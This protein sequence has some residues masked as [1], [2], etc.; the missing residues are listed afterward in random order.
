MHIFSDVEASGPKGLIKS[1][2]VEFINTKG[3]QPIKIS[4]EQPADSGRKQ[5]KKAA[6]VIHPQN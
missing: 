6:K 3:L 4:A 1:D 2:V 5:Q